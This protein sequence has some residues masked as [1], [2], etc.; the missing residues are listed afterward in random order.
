MPRT[1]SRGSAILKASLSALYYSGIDSLIGPLT[2]GTGAVF[3]LHH[4]L[5]G[6]TTAFAP[7][8]HLE[9]T[10]EFLDRTIRL[11][12]DRGYDVISLDDARVRLA[13]GDLGRPF[14]CF[15]FDGGYR[16]TFRNAYPAF[17]RHRLPFAVYVASDF[18]DGRGELWW[19]NLETLL[20]K[21][22]EVE[23]RI[24][25]ALRR[26]PCARPRAKTRAYHVIDRWLRQLP[27]REI[28][29]CVAE[30]C[31]RYG[32]DVDGLCGELAMTWS[33]I[34]EI[35]GDPLVTIGAHSRS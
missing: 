14:V 20:G 12:L 8:R 35:A 13:E 31:R 11:V 7:N 34:R 18:A 27:E 16:D 32:V 2:R 26:I 24:D 29:A 4:V 3:M 33:E 6:A 10:P 19:R 30:L 9:V 5:P 28:R 15:T 22:E 17:M 1:M 23:L 25:G 21:V